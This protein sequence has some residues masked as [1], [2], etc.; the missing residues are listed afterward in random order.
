MTPDP[1]PPAIGSINHVTLAVSDLRR[2][3][4]FYTGVLGCREHAR[5]TRGAYLS[6][7][8]SWLC[9]SLDT[10]QPRSDYTHLAFTMRAGDAAL[11]RERLAGATFWKDNRSEGESLY[12]LDPDGHRLE[13]HAGDLVSRLE[14]VR[15]VPYDGMQLPAPPPEPFAHAPVGTPRVL[16]VAG[17]VRAASVN[18]AFV[19]ALAERWSAS[20]SIERF[21]AFDRLPPLVPDAEPPTAHETLSRWQRAVSAADAVLFA[22]PEY[23][24]GLP[25]SVKNGLDHLV[26]GDAFID[27][28]FV[29][30]NLAPRAHA[31]QQQLTLILSTMS[32]VPLSP[33][34]HVLDVGS[35]A[36][37]VADRLDAPPLAA[38]LD[39][40]LRQLQSS[41]NDR[42]VLSGSGA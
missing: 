19:D 21:H 17:S 23:A 41:V 24:G 7:G 10:V 12:V 31:A 26:G 1:T 11:W 6:A 37:D 25:G 20:L 30:C 13:L 18:R 3:L 9:L 22:C 34:A 27:K 28:P 33:H 16:L 32:G 2:A 14:A 38:T 35:T 36:A 5:W 42:K 8:D 4:A 39:A 40:L 29:Q 15:R